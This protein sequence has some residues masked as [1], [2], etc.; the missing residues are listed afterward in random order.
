MR[1]LRVVKARLKRAANGVHLARLRPDRYTR[2]RSSWRRADVAAQMLELTNRQLR[3]P[4]RVPPYRSFREVL[5]P[6]TAADDLPKPAT[7]LDI[8]CGIGAYGELLERW[9]P[10]RFRYLGADYSE[11]ILAAA[12]TRW[13]GREFVRKD[14]YEDGA[15]DGFDIVFA[16]ALVDVLADYEAALR[17][18]LRS[19]ASFV[20]LHRQFMTSGEPHVDV[21]P[22][23]RGQWTYRSYI[24]R[25]RLFELA[26][27]SERRAI[28]EVVVDG[29]VR[30]FVFGQTT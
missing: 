28:A 16:S 29:D 5:A 11:E 26:E 10:G 3:E 23:Y 22:G 1:E 4:E 20:V 30:S 9:A 6:L 19:D 12:S 14:V 8:G 27:Q 21:E 18:L 13:P 25:D 24:T 17:A 2:Y 7:F 15:L